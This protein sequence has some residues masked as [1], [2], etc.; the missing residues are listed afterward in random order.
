MRKYFSYIFVI[1]LLVGIFSFG[2]K[3]QAVCY[4]YLTNRVLSTYTTSGPCTSNGNNWREPGQP[5]PVNGEVGAGGVRVDST[6]T[7]GTVKSFWGSLVDIVA[8]V[9]GAISIGI[10]KIASFFTY[11][12][13]VILNW[14]I[15]YS[16]LNMS[17]RLTDNANS[18]NQAWGVIRD[19]SNITFIFVLLYAAILTIFGMGDNKRLITNVVVVAILINFSL[20]FTKVVIDTSN[21]LAVMF[22]D[23]IAPGSL[24]VEAGLWGRT[25]VANSLMDFLSVQ[26]IWS[27]GNF[28]D[29]SNLLVI[30]VMGTI[31]SLIAAFVFFAVSIMFIIRLV[32]LTFVL[33]LSPLAFVSWILPGMKSN[34]DKWFS[35]LTGQAFFAPIYFMLTWVVILLSRSLFKPEAGST[36]LGVVAG[37]ASAGTTGAS[38][39]SIAMIVNFFIIIAMLITSLTIAKEWAGKAGPIVNKLT[40]WATGAAGNAA[41]GFAG[42]TGR[43][44]IGAYGNRMANSADLQRD[45]KE[46]SG[47]AGATARLKLYTAQKARSGTFDVRNATIPTNALGDAIEGTVG[48]TAIGKRMGLDEVRIGAIPVGEMANDQVGV[49]KPGTEGYKEEAEAKKKRMDTK[50][51][52]R[53]EE[54]RKALAK[55]IIEDGLSATATSAQIIEMQ[56]TIK[57]MSNKEILALDH[58]TLTNEKVAEALTAGHL[59]AV[60]DSEKSE[61]EKREI[62]NKHFAKVAESTEIL[63]TGIDPATGVALTDPVKKKHQAILRNISDKEID[64]VPISIFDPTKLDPSITTIEAERSRAFLRTITQPQ[65]DNLT[66]GDKLI[67]SEKQAVKDARNK[68]INDAFTA[69]NW[70]GTSDSAIELMRQMRPEALVQLDLT[71][72]TEPNIFELYSPALLNKMAARSELTEATAN[73][74]RTAIINA[75]PGATGSNQ[76]KAYNWLNG[77]GATIF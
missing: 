26:S 11:L 64:Y 40:S 56:K 9:P 20:F 74:I 68:P 34:W 63:R 59:K 37:T 31:F 38:G 13:G 41:F 10:L 69:M 21:V 45:A 36:L 73:A 1:I 12:S 52:D 42:W 46:K 3:A 19:I 60:N 61:S 14:I 25:G 27:A 58:N 51:K 75:G 76:E 70:T 8:Y 23:K 39:G 30:G 57:D 65:V 24:T 6:N 77:D 67:A 54:L 53:D 55:K 44:T 4:D 49:G 72:L 43:K 32:V 50:N 2:E 66:K 48:R 15:Q 71:K 28:S 29:G 17:D 18:I 7:N 16:V 22:Y 47:F 35:A 33:V 5:A 62:F